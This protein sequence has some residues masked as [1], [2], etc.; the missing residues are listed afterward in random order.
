MYAWI[1]M[2][3]KARGQRSTLNI[4]PRRLS[5]LGFERKSITCVAQRLGWLLS[6][7][8]KDPLAPTFPALG[9]HGWITNAG[10]LQV[11]WVSNSGPHVCV[12]SIC[13]SH[14]ARPALIAFHLEWIE[15]QVC[16]GPVIVSTCPL[17]AAYLVLTSPHIRA[18]IPNQPWPFPFYHE[19]SLLLFLLHWI[20]IPHSSLSN[21]ICM[22]RLALHVSFHVWSFRVI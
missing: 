1:H 20:L 15:P 17:L 6:C 8:P 10:C 2:N 12:S 7:R 11:S 14:L 4:I 22:S 16:G 21:P 19:I 13:D 3:M 9:L 18:S 5:T